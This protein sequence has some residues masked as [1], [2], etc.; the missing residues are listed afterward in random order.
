MKH[1]LWKLHFFKK[2]SENRILLKN[3]SCPFLEPV[4]VELPDIENEVHT[5]VS[6]AKYRESQPEPQ[7]TSHIN[8]ELIGP[9]SKDLLAVN[10]FLS[11]GEVQER[12]FPR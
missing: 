10:H 11:K 4:Q 7:G 5:Q 12:P 9:I 6:D 3:L 1:S 2:L 8:E